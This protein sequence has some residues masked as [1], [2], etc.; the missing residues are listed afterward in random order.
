MWRNFLTANP[1]GIT[2]PPIDDLLNVTPSYNTLNV[3]LRDEG[4]M[5]FVKYL[6]ASAGGSRWDIA[7][8]YTVGAAEMEED[9][10]S[11]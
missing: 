9:E 1:E 10:A 7:A 2:N 5:R 3:V 6:G 4:V 8:E 11:A